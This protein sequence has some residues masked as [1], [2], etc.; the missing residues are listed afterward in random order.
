M[1]TPSSWSS[2][3]APSS[4]SVWQRYGSGVPCSRP[5]PTRPASRSASASATRADLLGDLVAIRPLG[6]QVRAHPRDPLVVDAPVHV[7]GQR[8]DAVLELAGDPVALVGEVPAGVVGRCVGVVGAREEDLVQ[9]QV[10][11]PG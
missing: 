6:A 11:E 1:T 5:A 10:A 8:P 7:E 9:A 4:H 2:G 3:S